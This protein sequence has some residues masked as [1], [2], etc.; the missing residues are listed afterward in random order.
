MQEDGFKRGFSPVQC[1]LDGVVMYGSL[2]PRERCCSAADIQNEGA[3]ILTFLL[4][5]IRILISSSSES[6]FGDLQSNPYLTKPFLW[7][8]RYEIL[9]RTGRYPRSNEQLLS[10]MD[11]PVE[12]LIVRFVQSGYD[13]NLLRELGDEHQAIGEVHQCY[14]RALRRITQVAT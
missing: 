7:A 3:Q 8:A 13:A 4:M 10:M 11:D 14:M 9:L 6:G 1:Y 2:P 12:Q 5:S